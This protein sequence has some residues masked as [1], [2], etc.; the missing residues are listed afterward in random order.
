MDMLMVGYKFVRHGNV[1]WK[2]L[3]SR[4]KYHVGIIH[5]IPNLKT[6]NLY[7]MKPLHYDLVLS[8]F[9]L[10]NDQVESRTTPFQERGDDEGISVIERTP[11]IPG[12]TP[13]CYKQIHDQIQ[14]NSK[15]KATNEDCI[16]PL[17]GY[18]LLPFY[19][20]FV[21]QRESRTNLHQGRED[22]EHMGTS[23]M[24]FQESAQFSW[25]ELLSR[26]KQTHD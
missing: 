23:Y 14:R 11:I 2:E 18:Y 1:C 5:K 21:D 17:H 26:I 15:V 25:K 16:I 19:L 6:K 20:S 10:C 24:T 8:C 12:Q 22:D 4:T 9:L 7:I 13:S 3:L